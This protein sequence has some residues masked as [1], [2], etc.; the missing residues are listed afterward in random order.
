MIAIQPETGQVAQ[1]F[2]LQDL[3]NLGVIPLL[4]VFSRKITTNP[5]PTSA[6]G[7]WQST[8]SWFRRPVT[9]TATIISPPK[10]FQALPG[11]HTG[12]PPEP[13]SGSIMPAAAIFLLASGAGLPVIIFGKAEPP[14]SKKKDRLRPSPDIGLSCRRAAQSFL[15]KR[16]LLATGAWN[17]NM[18][19]KNAQRSMASRH[20]RLGLNVLSKATHRRGGQGK[21][22]HNRPRGAFQDRI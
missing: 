11:C 10:L 14:L 19:V 8:S 22:L 5:W 9:A 21:T 13:R 6:N 15:R 3:A 12:S 18:A 1:A 20:V 17:I 7:N 2:C 16:F 4:V